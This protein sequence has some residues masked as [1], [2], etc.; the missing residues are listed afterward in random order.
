M[1][2]IGLEYLY[3]QPG[4]DDEVQQKRLGQ[5]KN[6]TTRRGPQVIMQRELIR[7]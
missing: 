6:K 7:V 5:E 1:P 2:L 3:N 4:D